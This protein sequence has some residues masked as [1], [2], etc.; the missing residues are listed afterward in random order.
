MK[1]I[2]EL[3][4]IIILCF[5][6][7]GCNAY[8]AKDDTKTIESH[9]SNYIKTVEESPKMINDDS[10][11]DTNNDNLLIF[12]NSIYNIEL[13]MTE[14][15]VIDIHG[16]PL[17]IEKKESQDLRDERIY[18]YEFGEL[19][20]IEQDTY[21]NTF[22]VF[23]IYIN[24]SNTIV[25]EKIKVGDEKKDVISYLSIDNLEIENKIAWEEINAGREGEYWVNFDE[26]GDIYS[27]S[28]EYEYEVLHLTFL[29]YFED[30]IVN[31][32]GLSIPIN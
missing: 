14:E 15:E 25:L 6:I 20:F 4:F 31:G 24:N 23:E 7:V 17:S 21:E 2:L 22:F 16:Q 18:L 26:R 9:D 11:V 10:E 5:E 3:F 29:I 19:Y 27:I 8:E 32:F 30:E 1:K 13:Y 12:P 28:H